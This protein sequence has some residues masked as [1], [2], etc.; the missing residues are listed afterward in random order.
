MAGKK[1]ISVP[2][3][4]VEGDLKLTVEIDERRVS[5]AWCSGTMYRGF[6]QMMIGRGA[7]DGLVLTPRVCGI[8]GT[9]HLMA[10]VRAL[11]MAA[12]ANLPSNAI[13]IR[14]I[15]LM[16]EHMQSDIRHAFL[17]YTADFT[18]PAYRSVPLFEEAIRRYQPFRGESVI[19]VV[20]KT[21]SVLEIV[22]IVGGQWPHV[23]FMVPGGI[24]SNLS[25]T[26][27]IQCRLLLDDYRKWF[28]ARILGCTIDRFLEV[29]KVSDLEAWLEE[30]EAHRESD[31]G[32]FIRFALQIGLD[33]TGRAHDMFLSSGYL[34]LPEGTSVRGMNSQDR[35]VPSGFSRGTQTVDFDQL[36]I[37]E[38][39]RYS[40]FK[41]Y[42]GGKHPSEGITVP[43]ASG[44]GEE[45]Y[46]WAKA[47]R[48]L[49]EPVE[50]GPLAEMVVGK[51]PLFV[52]LINRSGGNSF[53]RQLAR[54]VRSCL[55]I[56][57]LGTW[58]SEVREEERFFVSPGKIE[59][60]EGYGL[61]HAAR[62]I[63]G[64]WVKIEKGRIQ[65]YQIIT[66]TAWH[67]SPRDSRGIRGPMEEALI[68]TPVK[69]PENP[70]ELGHVVRSFDPCLVCTVHTLHRGQK[71]GVM[72]FNTF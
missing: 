71:K 44:T 16:T 8:C 13:R 19:E 37:A 35:L 65:K 67:A 61:T 18:N 14:N 40:W 38:H 42:T 63:L 26:D 68:G 56:P 32:F 4:R 47:P 41:D 29:K 50:T 10:A 21:K 58:L 15:A 31:L 62:G 30:K 27:M 20:K 48:Y 34:D 45:K 1:I 6:E 55:L 28:E 51:N 17:M 23:S 64:H 52:D 9:A 33:K 66:P 60:G 46:S 2:I 7:L 69:D 39:V 49:E 59:D 3:N 36:Q 54:I 70:V 57:A 25:R 24:V 12:E 53:N 22:A 5:D 72:T 11:D 43:Y